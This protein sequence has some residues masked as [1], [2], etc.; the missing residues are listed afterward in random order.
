M[1]LGARQRDVL[2]WIGGQAA[3]LAAA[4]IVAGLGGAY[5]PNRLLRTLLFHVQARD[6][7]TFGTLAALVLVVSLAA[8][9]IPARRAARVRSDDSASARVGPRLSAP[10]LH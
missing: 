2:R 4:G 10:V 8:V 7:A 1:A 3:M 5:W 9:A 6:P